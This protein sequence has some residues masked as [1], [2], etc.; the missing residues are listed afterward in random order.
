MF[1]NIVMLLGGGL[2]V[3]VVGLL[4]WNQ[5]RQDWMQ[6]KKPNRKEQ[7]IRDPKLR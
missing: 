3:L 4:L 6:N 1:H 5:T 2:T 7:S